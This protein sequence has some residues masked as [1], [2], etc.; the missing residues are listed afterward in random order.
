VVTP[1]VA[2]P[3]VELVASPLAVPVR[4]GIPRVTPGTPLAAP[5]PIA[6]FVASD[7][8]IALVL[9]GGA[10]SVEPEALGDLAE[11]AAGEAAFARI[12]AHHGAQGAFA[13]LRVG[14]DAR[15]VRV[16]SGTHSP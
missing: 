7:T 2:L 14:R 13:A 5:A 16:R 1:G 12:A 8:G 11:G 6:I 4:R 10:S 15:G 9:E 3:E